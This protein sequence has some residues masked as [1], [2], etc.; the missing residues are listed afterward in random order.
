MASL[1]KTIETFCPHCQELESAS[2][3]GD[4]QRIRCTKCSQSLFQNCTDDFLSHR[5][6]NQC[7]ACGCTHLFR[8][9][10]FN[11]RLGVA[12]LVVGVVLA[13]FTYGIS[14]LIVTVVDLI[15]Y[16][17]VKEVGVC[18]Q[19]SAIYRGFPTAKDLEPFQLSLHDHYRI[20][21]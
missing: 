12:I 8:Q 21:V 10:D 1:S 13:F 16:S 19:C 5:T 17:R 18:Y 4:I 3:E 20:K 9:K 14:L 7:A 11:R 6:L 2:G 15:F